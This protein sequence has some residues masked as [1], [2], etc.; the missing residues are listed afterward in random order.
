MSR[1]KI[2]LPSSG[3]IDMYDDVS[4]PLNF[5]IADIRFPEKRN[6]NY[7]KTIKIPGTKNNNLLFG[8]IFDVNI[9]DG[10]FNPNAKVKAILTIDDENQI[11]G[12]IQMLSITINDDNKIEYEVTILGNV[13]N[14][15]NALGTAELTAL[16]MSAYNHTYDYATQIASWTNDYTDGYC[17]PLIDYGYDNNLTSVNVEHLFP[18]VFLRTYIDAI[19]R[20]VGYTYSSTFFDSDYFKKLIVPANAGKV[21]LT[22][23]QIAPR[24]YEATQTVQT[25]GTIQSVYDSFF[26]LWEGTFAKQDVIYNN[27]ISDVSNQYNPATGEWTVYKTGYYSL[28]ANG[29]STVSFLSV[30]TSMG[31]VLNLE[32][33]PYYGSTYSN[34]AQAY[35]VIVSG[36][37]TMYV[38]VSNL[39]FNAGDKVKVTLSAKTTSL[40]LFETD[41]ALTFNGGTF[42]NQVVNSG[43][44]D[45][46][47]ITIN[48]VTPLKIKQKDFLLS[49]IKMFNLYIDLDPNNDNNLLIETRD[50]FYS[51]GTNVDWSYK[52]DNSK[53]IDIKPMGDLD[54]KEFNFTYTDDTDYFNKKYK[55]G[56]AETYGRFRYVTDNEFLSGTSENKVI[57]SPT[58]LIGDTASDR[59][60]SRIWDVDSSNIVKSKGFNIRLLYNGGVKTSN[61]AYQYNGRIS[62]VH[63][64]T[65]YLYSGHVDNPVSPTLDLSFGVPQEIYY[66]TELYTNNNIFNRFHKKL[67]DEITDRDSKILTAYF[68]LRP[69]DIRTLDFRNQFYF[70][71]DYFRLNKVFDYDPLKNDVTKCEFIKIKDSGTFTPTLHTMLGGISSAFGESN[72]IPPIINTWNAGTIDNIRITG[73]ARAMTGGTDNI[74]N[75][76]VRSCIVNGNSNVIGDS[77]NVTLLGSSGCIVGSGISNVTLIN[78]FDT[79]IT[80][81]NS[82]YINGVVLN[83]DSLNQTKTVTIPSADVLNIFTTPY[84]LIPSPGA[85]YYIQVLTASCKINFNTTAYSTNTTLN[86]LTDTAIRVQHSFSNVLNAT[87][88]RI[89]V[90][91]QQSISGA[92]DT[93]LISDKGV[94]L[95]AQTG[96]P[97]TGD[98][99]IIIYLTYRIIQE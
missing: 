91:S 94:Y 69:S 38:G 9:T 35:H 59:V 13:G 70:Q 7:S 61:V 46:D 36:T 4:T 39:F 95:K 8:N 55:D 40:T 32:W 10:S 1:T 93:Q 28:G 75:D 73:G 80:E 14:I 77:E 84:L 19:F 79:E 11:N 3:S 18:S 57:F 45:G 52:L 49:V 2:F 92:A 27:E 68:Y 87:L 64:V 66:D 34:I 72:E 76:N 89:S 22:D 51:S 25:S 53:P 23:V 37:N 78:T 44:I 88:S 86:V 98:S 67:I 48:Q 47:A 21:V 17:Y 99:D 54:N 90:S 24:L 96:N 58:P 50:D 30:A 16:D 56:Y 60:I 62:G 33:K 41:G 6:S 29:T 42:K 31:G 97:T 26:G 81:S 85:G 74:Y 82:M 5:S 71:N 12:Y 65:Q 20:S 15:F 63:T 83:E 43:L